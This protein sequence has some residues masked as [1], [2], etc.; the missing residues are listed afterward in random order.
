METGARVWLYNPNGEDPWILCQ[1]S[2]RSDIEI[3]LFQVSNPS[4]CFSRPRINLVDGN[5]VL[6]LKYK[7]VELANTIIPDKSEANDDDIIKLT[8]L[9]D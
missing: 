6:D 1:V 5:D 7:D 9:K 3:N 2:S 8:H 4:T